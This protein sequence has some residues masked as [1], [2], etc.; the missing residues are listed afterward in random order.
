MAKIDGDCD[1]VPNPTTS[2]SIYRLGLRPGTVFFVMLALHWHQQ[3]HTTAPYPDTASTVPVPQASA[4]CRS[5]ERRA[6]SRPSGFSCNLPGGNEPELSRVGDNR[7]V[8]LLS[9]MRCVGG[10]GLILLY[11]H[12]VRGCI[13]NAGVLNDKSRGRRLVFQGFSCSFMK[14]M[15]KLSTNEQQTYLLCNARP[16]SSS[17]CFSRVVVLLH[18]YKHYQLMCLTPVNVEGNSQLKG[19]KHAVSLP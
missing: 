16:K 17:C 4:E 10:G 18:Y 14:F 13:G 1:D 7:C 3:W 2:Y 19:E 15:R 5:E 11:L 9:V 6:F 12:P 8:V